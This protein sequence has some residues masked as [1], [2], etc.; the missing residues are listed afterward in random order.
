MSSEDGLR[1]RHTSTNASNN[2]EQRQ[3]NLSADQTSYYSQYLPQTVL[4]NVGAGPPMTV[5]GYNM[6]AL[7]MQQAAMYSWMQQ[8]YSQ[9]MEQCLRV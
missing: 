9:Y 8:V 1:Q 5:P 4:T 3:T 6:Q 7:A 2:H